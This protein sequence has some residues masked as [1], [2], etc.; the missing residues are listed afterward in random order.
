M[1][2]KPLLLFLLAAALFQACEKQVP[3]QPPPGQPQLTFHYVPDS[4]L[5][6]SPEP[7]LIMAAVADPR[8]PSPVTGVRVTL[9]SQAGQPLASG[10]MWD[11]G[12][13]GDILAGDQVYTFSFVPKKLALSPGWIRVVCT[14]LE[15]GGETSVSAEDTLAVVPGG[16][17]P[18]KITAAVLPETLSV[19]KDT[20]FSLQA[21]LNDPDSDL[22]VLEIAVLE[23]DARQPLQTLQI[24]V[25]GA[26]DTVVQ[27]LSTSLFTPNQMDYF[28]RLVAV[29]AAGNRSLPAVRLLHFK[30]YFKNDPPQ[31]LE[32]IAPD[33]VSRS[34]QNTFLLEARVTDPQGLRD[35]ARVVL[36]TYLPSGQI[37]NNSPFFLRDDGF[38][39]DRVPGD[40]IY[41]Q[42]FQV[43][44]DTPTGTYRFDVYAEDQSGLKSPVKSHFL[45]VI[46]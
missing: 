28:F 46:E 20:L 33:T 10:D 1:T 30:R 21:V 5:A 8:S 32:I 27:N 4:V 9:F 12:K 36:N 38:G 16:G 19:V 37:T 25:S 31:V 26:A 42:T 39:G 34:Q 23:A 15:S 18:P 44:S 35:I 40:G 22:A 45:T 6:A 24:P 11:T 41:S 43:P 14:L 17:F 2:K 29:D 13:D 7:V 3:V